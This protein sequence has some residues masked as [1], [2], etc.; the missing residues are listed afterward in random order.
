[1]RFVL[2]KIGFLPVTVMDI[3]DIIVMSYIIYRAYYF[4]RGSRGAQMLAGLVI[5]MTLSI[6]APLFQMRGLSWIFEN[7]R[8]VWLIAFVIIFQP[9]LRRLLIYV[10]QSPIVRRLFKVSS[11]KVI[12]VVV[13]ATKALR[14]RGYGALIVMARETGLKMITETGVRI[15]AE[16][17]TPLILSLFNPRAPLHDGAVV[18][19]ND[20]IEAAKCILPLAD[21]DQSKS[22]YGTRH[23][24]A[25]GLSEESDAMVIVVSE[26]TG[27][28]SI[29]V[30][31]KLKYDL[32]EDEIEKKLVEGYRYEN[33]SI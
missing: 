15:Q 13:E 16:V 10:G 31:G 4:L 29:A 2:F 14:E 33:S 30:G 5:I 28:I 25:I 20:I 1:M 26:E 22:E 24:A 11:S 8:T 18:I 7:L 23:R 32:D 17:S 21:I 3:L 12:D 19:Q 6:I 27:K 9:E